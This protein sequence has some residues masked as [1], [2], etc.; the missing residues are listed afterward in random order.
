MPADQGWFTQLFSKEAF[1]PLTMGENY[2]VRVGKLWFL[3]SNL[4]Y[5]IGQKVEYF[6]RDSEKFD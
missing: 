2:T 3:P 4:F 1:G 6:K 5:E